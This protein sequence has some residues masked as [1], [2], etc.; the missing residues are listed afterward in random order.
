M[1]IALILLSLMLAA[2]AVADAASV[3]YVENGEVW[4][5]S[6]DGATKVAPRRARWSTPTARPRSGWRS[7]RPT[8]AGIVAVRNKPGK[9]SK[10]SW[11]KVWEPNGTS[12]VEGP[13]TAPAAGSST[14]IRSA[15]TSPPT[16]RTWS[17]GSPTAAGAA[18][19]TSAAAP[20]SGRSAP[21]SL[22]P[23]TISGYE[24]PTLFGSRVIAKT[25]S[26][27]NVQSSGT[28]TGTTSSPGWTCR[29]P[30][31][32]CAAR[33]SP[34]RARSPRT[35]SSSGTTAGQAIG[36]IGVASIAGVDAPF[37]PGRRRLLPPGLR[38]RQGRLALPG[39]PLDRVDRRSGPEGRG[40]RR[41]PPTTLHA[42]V[43]AGRDRGRRHERVDRRGRRERVPAAA[44]P[45]PVT[46]PP[47]PATAPVT[48]APPKAPALPAKVTAKSLTSGLKITVG[49]PGKVTVTATRR[50]EEGRQRARRPRRPP[51][52]SRSSSS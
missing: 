26:V 12:T 37:T 50:Q 27:I 16:A 29:A 46:T 36:K 3:A 22:D 2:P 7:R 44:S 52:R 40:R 5:S 1:R 34:P 43:A 32:T 41:R 23:I 48:P 42:R 47:T 14:S 19:S 18:R 6:L 11:F 30:G 33:T 15:W 39:R 45:P 10:L 17:T 8:A 35:R 25:G 9:T 38:R 20:T 51:G 28:P 4:V 13:L 49:A 21:A 24:E 31:S